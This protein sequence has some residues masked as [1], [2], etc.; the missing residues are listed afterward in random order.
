MAKKTEAYECD[1]CG[2]IFTSEMA[3]ER[4]NHSKKAKTRGDPVCRIY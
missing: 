2:K 3:A 1:E 4:C